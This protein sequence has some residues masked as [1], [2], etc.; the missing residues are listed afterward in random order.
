MFALTLLGAAVTLI[1][2]G[3]MQSGA[4][5]SVPASVNG[6]NRPIFALY[7]ARS[8]GDLAFITGPGAAAIRDWMQGIQALDNWFPLAYGGMA[9][10]F[11]AGLGL[12][13]RKLAFLGIVLVA[14]AIVA[15][16]AENA[17]ANRILADLDAGRHPAAELDAMWRHTWIKW[18]L[19]AAYSGVLS[20]LLATDGRRLLA[21]IP[22]LTAIAFVVTYFTAADPDVFRVT[23]LLLVAFML[24]FPV[25]AIFY[26]RAR[27]RR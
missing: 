20:Y 10:A 23:N 12:R 15:D 25:A 26:L 27:D 14:G 16:W 13:G 21:I 7:F 3:L 17:V 8:V 24:T 22:G 6:F 9:M 5:E 18:G 19:I 4:P 1:F 11:F 2:A